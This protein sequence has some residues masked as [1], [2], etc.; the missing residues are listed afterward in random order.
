MKQ[1]N[2]LFPG[3]GSQ[4]IGMANQFKDIAECWEIFQRADECLGFSLSQLC[5]DGD[6]EVLKQTEN[7]QPAI[8]ATSTA[9]YTLLKK[10]YPELNINTVLGHSVGE[11]AALVAASS[12]KLEDALKAVK[13]RG[14]LMQDSVPLGVGAMYAILKIPGATV[15]EAC[16]AVSDDNEQ[17]MPANF[18]D[19]TQTVISGHTA[20]CE[21]AVQ[22]LK[23]NYEG[24]M[25]A[26]PLKVSAPFHSSLMQTAQDKMVAV[27]DDITIEP[28]KLDYIANIDAQ[29]YTTGTGSETIKKNLIQQVS[30]SVLWYPSFERFGTNDVFI[31]VGAG[32]VLTGLNRKINSEFKTFTMDVDNLEESL[33]G[34]LNEHSIL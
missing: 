9:Y 30:G 32:K 24:S 8:V 10:L 6:E 18:N 21:K 7:T 25:R 5:L 16:E 28:N 34:F 12:L 29:T 22:W 19:P 33:K 15:K 23:D 13:A 11:Y 1:V 31:E 4:Y 26:M 3:Q 2:L 17:V 27:L 14:R 20:A